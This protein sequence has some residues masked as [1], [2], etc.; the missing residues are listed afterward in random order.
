MHDGACFIR[1]V[2]REKFIGNGANR[3]HGMAA[4]VSLTRDDELRIRSPLTE[5]L[6]DGRNCRFCN[7]GT[8]DG[9]EREPFNIVRQSSERGLQRT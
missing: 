3:E 8:I 5:S 4:L 7:S 2:E 9:N 6:R 1:G